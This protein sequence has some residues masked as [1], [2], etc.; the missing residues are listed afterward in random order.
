MRLEPAMRFVG[1]VTFQALTGRRVLTSLWHE[2]SACEVEHIALS[3]SSDLILVAPATANIVGKIAGGIADDI[4]STLVLGA[5]C[6]V[7]LAPAM[8]VRMLNNAAVVRN[9]KTL[10]ERSFRIIEPGEGWL[11]CRTVGS[12]RMAEPREI[13]ET[14]LPILTAKSPKQGTDTE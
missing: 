10:G 3:G 13:L 7:V 5:A 6:P 9:I 11:A 1:V 12:G 14:I 4:V 2:Q 8:N